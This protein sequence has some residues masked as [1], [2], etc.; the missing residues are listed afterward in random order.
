MTSA[1]MTGDRPAL[2]VVM[3][4]SGSGKSTVGAA[5]ARRIGVPFADA[6]GIHPPDNIAK[7]AAGTPLDDADR[8]PW[9]QLVGRWLADHDESGGVISCSALRVVYRDLL[10]AHA[11][12]VRF[13]HLHGTR[14]SIARRLAGRAGHFMPPALLDSQLADLEP[15]AP[16]EA[17]LSIEIGLPVAAVV[18]EYV[19]R[20]AGSD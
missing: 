7:M 13:L 4:V 11:P 16:G 2:L 19:R 14:G 12:R 17:G 3:G 20:V 6:D 5:I 18:E 10:R 9:L 8:L 15:L 1:G